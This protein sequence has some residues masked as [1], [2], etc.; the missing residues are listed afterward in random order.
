M[1]VQKQ[2]RWGLVEILVCRYPDFAS[3]FVFPLQVQLSEQLDVVLLPKE[4]VD[5][6]TLLNLV[7]CVE[8]LS[9]PC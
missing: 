1:S 8:S 6:F 5:T 2:L 3:F 9:V 7:K 4:I